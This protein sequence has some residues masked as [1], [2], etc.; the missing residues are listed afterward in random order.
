MTLSV[1]TDV[2]DPDLDEPLACECRHD[3]GPCGEPATARVTAVCREPGCDC[4]AWVGMACSYCLISW[5]RMA[6]RD[7]VQLRVHPLR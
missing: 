5:K 3:G 1:V 7:G 4:G 6:R 2:A